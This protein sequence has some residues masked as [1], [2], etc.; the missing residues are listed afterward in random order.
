MVGAALA[1]GPQTR[2]DPLDAHAPVPPA[3][4]ALTGVDLSEVTIAFAVWFYLG[5]SM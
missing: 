5:L 3:V 2:P 1:Q 4:H